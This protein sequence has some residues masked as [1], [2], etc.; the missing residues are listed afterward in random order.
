MQ[1]RNLYIFI[2]NSNFRVAD[3]TLE[4]RKVVYLVNIYVIHQ[5]DWFYQI[6]V[7][8]KI[9]RKSFTVMVK[10]I[11]KLLA[12]GTHWPYNFYSKMDI[13][14]SLFLS[15]WVKLLMSSLD[16]II[17]PNVW[18]LEKCLVHV[19][20]GKFWNFRIAEISLIAGFFTLE[21]FGFCNPWKKLKTLQ[22]CNKGSNYQ[23]FW[24]FGDFGLNG[25]VQKP[26]TNTNRTKLS[27]YSVVSFEF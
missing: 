26:L 17:F 24:L 19:K 1:I 10:R 4:S 13:F 11:R 12:G 22:K 6:L 15:P 16:V 3:I 25:K 23:Q 2:G 7:I 9:L 20:N 5:L 18:N 27:W 21:L 14:Y 8:T